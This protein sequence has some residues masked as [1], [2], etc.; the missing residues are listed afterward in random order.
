MV[1]MIHANAASLISRNSELWMKQQGTQDEYDQNG[2]SQ[3]DVGEETLTFKC[4]G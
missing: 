3:P 2:V 4:R 1:I